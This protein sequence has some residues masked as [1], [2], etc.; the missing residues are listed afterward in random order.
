MSRGKA[1]AMRRSAMRNGILSQKSELETFILPEVISAE[2]RH[3][4]MDFLEHNRSQPI[5]IEAENVRKICSLGVQAL[6]MAMSTWKKDHVEIDIRNPSCEL[7]SAVS[8]LGLSNEFN[9]SEV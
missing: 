2:Q 5:A 1:A 8:T 6:Y 4:L 7:L 3:K 9:V